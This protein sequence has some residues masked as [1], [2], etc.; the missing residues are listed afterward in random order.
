MLPRLIGMIHLGALPGSPGFDG[1]FDAVLA[2]AVSDARI[3]HR[4]GFE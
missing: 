2:A 4:V 1:D 3:L